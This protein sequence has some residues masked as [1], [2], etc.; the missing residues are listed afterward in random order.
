MDLRCSSITF[1]IAAC[2]P[3]SYRGDLDDDLS[4]RPCSPGF[5]TG[6]AINGSITP[7]NIGCQCNNGNCTSGA[8][9]YN[10]NESHLLNSI[11]LQF[12]C[13]P[14]SLFNCLSQLTY[15]HIII[16][17]IRYNADLME[18]YSD[19]KPVNGEN[20]YCCLS[21]LITYFAEFAHDL[22]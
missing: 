16:N 18:N 1:L 5:G 20:N 14:S 12:V 15:H 13:F 6:P 22:L 10:N 4:C 11:T 2:P 17:A 7:D 3:D 9:H 8:D 21:F 19:F